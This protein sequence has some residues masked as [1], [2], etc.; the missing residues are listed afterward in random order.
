VPP[1]RGILETA[2]KRRGFSFIS[3]VCRAAASLVSIPDSALAKL[4]DIGLTLPQVD[5]FCDAPAR[6]P[7]REA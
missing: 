6:E 5:L 3:M 7:A 2:P 1:V 4:V